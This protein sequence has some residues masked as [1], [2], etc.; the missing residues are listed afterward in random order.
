MMLHGEGGLAL[1]Q[2]TQ[3]TSWIAQGAGVGV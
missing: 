1:A 3:A 2:G